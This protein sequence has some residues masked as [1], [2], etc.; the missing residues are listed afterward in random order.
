M[1][2][3]LLLLCKF[4]HLAAWLP[5]T[6][7]FGCVFCHSQASCPFVA[8]AKPVMITFHES[9]KGASTGWLVARQGVLVLFNPCSVMF[10]G[11]FSATGCFYNRVSAPA[12]PQSTVE[13]WAS[14]RPWFEYFQHIELNLSGSRAALGLVSR[15][16]QALS[17]GS[18]WLALLPKRGNFWC[19]QA[20]EGSEVK[21]CVPVACPWLDLLR[22]HFGAVCL[23]AQLSRAPLRSGPASLSE[24]ELSAGF[25]LPETTLMTISKKCVELLRAQANQVLPPQPSLW[26]PWLTYQLNASTLCLQRHRAQAVVIPAVKALLRDMASLSVLEHLK[27]LLLWTDHRGSDVQLGTGLVQDGFAQVAPYPRSAVQQ[28][29]W[30]AEQHLNVLDLTGLLNYLRMRTGTGVLQNVK[31]FHTFLQPGGTIG[32]R[33]GAF[34]FPCPQ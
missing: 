5:S 12:G 34:L 28:Y 24:V 21:C 31:L 4:P 25:F 33:K 18:F 27:A 17:D 20:F 32:I 2:V 11:S 29:R 16:R 7:L 8:F 13:F 9:L 26:D 3:R 22:F 23:V 14:L 10:Q 1:V 6:F 19:S 15:F 30:R